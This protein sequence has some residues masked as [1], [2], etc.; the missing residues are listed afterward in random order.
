[1]EINTTKHFSPLKDK[2]NSSMSTRFDR[3]GEQNN[4]NRI[5]HNPNQTTYDIHNQSLLNDTTK[6]FMR[7]PQIPKPNR[8]R[9]QF[10]GSH[11]LSMDAG[12]VSMIDD[13]EYEVNQR[14]EPKIV[15]IFKKNKSI[16]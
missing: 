3:S 12:F 13:E 11:D 10:L 6:V 7:Q 15:K 16:I 9:S 4:S 1:M 14:G 2:L 5:N 8:N